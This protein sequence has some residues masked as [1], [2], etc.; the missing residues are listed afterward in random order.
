MPDIFQN[1]FNSIKKKK[2]SPPPGLY[3]ARKLLLLAGWH[4]GRRFLAGRSA[5]SWMGW[6]RA[7]VRACVTAQHWR[8][9]DERRLYLFAVAVTGHVV[10]IDASTVLLLPWPRQ[11]SYC[12]SPLRLRGVTRRGT[13]AR[14][15]KVT[16]VQTDTTACQPLYLQYCIVPCFHSMYFTSP[17]LLKRN[18]PFP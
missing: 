3:G 14:V 1:D 17:H 6:D 16:R 18:F 4:R 15:T 5:S 2:A 10:A 9:E 12:S 7:R 11:H 13:T 8:E